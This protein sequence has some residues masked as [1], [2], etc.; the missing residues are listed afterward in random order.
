MF[1]RTHQV[2]P[3]LLVALLSL[4]PASSQI[5]PS[6]STNFTPATLKL[7]AT[8]LTN[9]R[10]TSGSAGGNL[11]TSEASTPPTFRLSDES[12]LSPGARYT[13]LLLDPDTPAVGGNGDESYLH[14]LGTGYAL[15]D[16]AAD[17]DARQ[18]ISESKPK[19]EYQGPKVTDDD[20]RYVVLLYV[21]KDG[22]EPTVTETKREEFSVE[23]FMKDS[24]IGQPVA[25][26]YFQTAKNDT[27]KRRRRDEVDDRMAEIERAPL[28]V[29]R[30]RSD[31][32][33]L[34]RAVRGSIGRK[35]PT[36]RYRRN[37][38][39]EAWKE[40]MKK[41]LERLGPRNEKRDFIEELDEHW[42]EKVKILESK[43]PMKPKRQLIED[44]QG[45]EWKPTVAS[46]QYSKRQPIDELDNAWKEKAAGLG[47]RN[48]KRQLVEEQQGDE[49][50]PS[51][52]GPQ[53]S[54]RESI[55]KRDEA[56]KR[57]VAGL[58]P[59]RKNRRKR[60]SPLV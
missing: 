58:G 44:E 33:E 56:W 7:E 50:K 57:K 26:L 13:I 1:L 22:A 6:W 9:I 28:G 4:N 3:V 37:A 11:F 8:Y 41:V 32:R 53:Y 29:L 36:G 20:H 5:P 31:L 51:A 25:G 19:V 16:G 34:D 12:D 45:D 39:S 55:D 18:L 59:R 43:K 15:R 40:A 23:K 2:F 10:L 49:W 27:G 35:W 46:P 24:G 17:A 48:P 47:P 42:K 54:K 60:G 21:Q 14:F 38:A 30:K 52:T